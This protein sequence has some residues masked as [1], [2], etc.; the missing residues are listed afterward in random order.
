MNTDYILKERAKQ[1]CLTEENKIIMETV[2]MP[3]MSGGIDRLKI[4]LSNVTWEEFDKLCVLVSNLTRKR[5][6]K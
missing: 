5:K 3:E 6:G 4:T 2:P 1:A